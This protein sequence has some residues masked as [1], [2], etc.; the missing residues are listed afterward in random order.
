MEKGKILYFEL[1]SNGE[2]VVDGLHNGYVL[3]HI[4]DYYEA[5]RQNVNKLLYPYRLVE[6]EY[7]PDDPEFKDYKVFNCVLAPKRIPRNLPP[8]Y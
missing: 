5:M 8:G 1:M 6:T 3:V 4:D 2:W 7:K